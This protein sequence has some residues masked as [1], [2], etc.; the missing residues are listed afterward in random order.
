MNPVLSDRRKDEL[1]LHLRIPADKS[2]LANAPLTLDGI[3][4]HYNVEDTSRARIKV[5]LE[6]AL[7]GSIELSYLQAQGLFDLK[8][9]VFKDKLQI[10]VEDFM[11]NDQIALIETPNEQQ[12][13]E[14]LDSAVNLTDG[15]VLI[16][17]S[18][19]NSCYSMQFNLAVVE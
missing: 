1:S 16:K 7:I 19:R 17:E 3:C 18:G 14:K 11:L 10:T 2:Y 9:S 6:T 8:F 13:R 5:A 12:I 4:E 15:F